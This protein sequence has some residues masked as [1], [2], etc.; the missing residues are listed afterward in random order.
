MCSAGVFV[1][2]LRSKLLTGNDLCNEL[3]DL[4]GIKTVH[5]TV[6]GDFGI[7]LALVGDL[8][9]GIG[10]GKPCNQNR[11]GMSTLLSQLAS[12][13]FVFSGLT[14]VVVSDVTVPRYA[15]FS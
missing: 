15:P 6:A 5:D 3:Q 9:T 14:D 4:C 1:C 11:I 10:N 8:C 7:C 13:Q 12:P 2:C